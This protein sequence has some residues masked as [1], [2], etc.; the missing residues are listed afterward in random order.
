ME[1]T[2]MHVH[3]HTF[4]QPEISTMH[5]GWPSAA[6]ACGWDSGPN[7]CR[8][9]NGSN[10]AAF[11][12]ALNCLCKP[13]KGEQRGAPSARWYLNGCQTARTAVNPRGDAADKSKWMRQWIPHSRTLSRRS[14]WSPEKTLTT[15]KPETDARFSEGIRYSKSKY[16]GLAVIIGLDGRRD[17]W[18]TPLQPVCVWN[19]RKE[20][21]RPLT[22]STWA[23]S[24]VSD[25]VQDAI[26]TKSLWP[27]VIAD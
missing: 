11:R 23:A 26:K 22:C 6:A 13:F 19:H 25:S 17:G 4:L 18:F 27:Q 3:I 7:L 24:A 16:G 2:G 8:S 12:S 15:G 20:A 10:M 21:T 1:H 9:D 14:L 5:W